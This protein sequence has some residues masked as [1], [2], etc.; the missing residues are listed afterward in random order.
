MSFRTHGAVKRS[1][2]FALKAF[3]V[4]LIALSSQ[5]AAAG[6]PTLYGKILLTANSYDLE[7]NNF[8]L[9]A[10]GATTYKHTGATGVATELDSVAVE[11]TGSR[12]GVQGDFGV[13]H[14]LTVFYRIEYGID[15]D[16][17]TNS[18]G[19]ELSQRNVFAGIRSADWGQVLVGKND[20]PLKTLQTTS[21]LR[22][23]LDRFNDYPL[24]DIGTYLAGENRPDNVI[25]YTSPIIL[26]GLEVN[27]AAI[28]AEETGV[29]VNATNQQNDNGFAT[30]KSLSVVYGKAKWYVGAAYETNVAT[31]DTLRLAG[32]VTIG[33]V[34]LGGFYQT[35][36]RH[37]DYDTIGGLTSTFVGS[38]VNSQG[39]QNGLNPLAEWDGAAGTAYK[40]QDA[41][42]LNGQWKIAG[43][44]VA[45]VQVAQATSTPSAAFADV[46][47]D[48]AAIGVDYNLSE[49]ARIFSYYAS[50]KTRGD[51]KINTVA[52][53]DKT[54]AVGLDLRF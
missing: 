33:P 50:L 12:L 9:T 37:E 40:E 19:R 16:N 1:S 6:F 25:Q 7:K 22:T 45:K 29:A 31:A 2:H 51:Q 15:V 34:K 14:D 18:N 53:V 28:Q 38:A 23:D 42:V 46:D 26:G 27:L 24:A 35:A 43:P 20:T 5:Q 48:A 41:V 10:A 32:E 4:S 13:A 47:T 17:G 21:V 54:Y 49:A 11:S 52:S 30:G 8:A 3:Y 36:E 39:V 44:W